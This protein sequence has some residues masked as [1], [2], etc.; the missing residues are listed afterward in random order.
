MSE[1]VYPSNEKKSDNSMTVKEWMVTYLI[2]FFA[3]I[4]PLLNI[5]ILL[6]WAFSEETKPCKKNWAKA[7]LIFILIVMAIALF[8]ILIYGASMASMMN[9][10]SNM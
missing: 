5:I 2:L 1:Q 8:F 10:M 4:I 7:S 3:S 6:Y 9:G